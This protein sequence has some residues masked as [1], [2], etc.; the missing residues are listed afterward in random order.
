MNARAIAGTLVVL[1]VAV[2]LGFVVS[3]S[4]DGWADW[5]VFG[6]VIC[7]ALGGAIAVW[8]REYPAQSK[9]RTF[10]RDSDSRW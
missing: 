7:A 2:A 9:K 3:D 6:V 1:A 4:A 8:N 10:T 5:V